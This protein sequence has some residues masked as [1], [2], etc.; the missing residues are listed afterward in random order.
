MITVHKSY[1]TTV[2]KTFIQGREQSATRE[3]LFYFYNSLIF[4]IAF[5]LL[6]LLH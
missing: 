4:Q 2:L 6:K 1:C 5:G 3:F